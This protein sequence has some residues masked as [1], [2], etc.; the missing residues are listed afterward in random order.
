MCVVELD[1]GRKKRDIHIER[2]K[3]TSTE[4][5][6][7]QK[8]DT[9]D[10]GSFI[11]TGLG[12]ASQLFYLGLEVHIS[13]IKNGTHSFKLPL[14]LAQFFLHY[15]VISTLLFRQMNVILFRSPE[16]KSQVSC[17]CHRVACIVVHLSVRR[18]LFAFSTAWWILMKL[19][20]DR[21]LTAPYKCCCLLARPA[22]IQS[23]DLSYILQYRYY[24]KYCNCILDNKCIT[25]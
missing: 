4:L 24:R 10:G 12:D 7:R 22:K 3:R 21:V 13:N 19:C 20:K 5:V 1:S 2:R 9:S 18:Q 6:K 15:C 16:P 11:Y 23:R 14:Y 17:Y 25:W 8:R